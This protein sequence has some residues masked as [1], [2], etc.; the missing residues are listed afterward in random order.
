VLHLDDPTWRLA[1]SLAVGVFIS[2]TPFYGLQ[3]LLAVGVAVPCRLNRAATVAGAWLNLP[4]FAPLVY[5][6]A[7][8][9][10]TLLVPDPS[11]TRGV[12]LTQMLTRPDSLAWSDLPILLDH[13]S[14]PLLVGTSVLGSLA[15]VITYVVAYRLIARRRASPGP[16]APPGPTGY[17]GTRGAPLTGRAIPTKEPRA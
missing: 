2:F 8:R 4:W 6:S 16:P 17:H 1:L 7:L 14:L 9:F 13:V 12:W 15:G 3:T 10:G 5:A 11:G